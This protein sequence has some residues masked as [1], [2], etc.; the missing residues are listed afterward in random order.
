MLVFR[1][2][3]LTANSL[4]TYNNKEYGKKTER[5]IYRST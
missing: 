2:F 5:R 4:L 1:F 3:K